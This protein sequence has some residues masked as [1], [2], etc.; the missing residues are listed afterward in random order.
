M[1]G[2]GAEVRPT[3]KG[4]AMIR[5]IYL[6]GGVR[7][8]VGAFGGAFSEV[9][10]PVLGSA[11]IKAAVARAN[12]PADAVDEVIFGNVISAGLGQNVARQCSIGGRTESRRSGRRR[13]IKSA[14]R[15]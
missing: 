1:L 3:R 13:S 8:A 10:A 5:E 15:G 14:V 12:I 6:A 7:T 11:A 4:K 9:P 2:D